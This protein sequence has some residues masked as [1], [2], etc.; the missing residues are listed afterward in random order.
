MLCALTLAAAGV[1]R[2]AYQPVAI[3]NSS[4]NADVIVEKTATPY[5]PILTSASI[6]QGTNNY[7]ATLFEVGLDTNNP[8][9]GV[10]AHGSTF[11]AYDN[12]NYSYKMAPTFVGPNGILMDSQVTNGTFTLVT[13]AAYATLSFIGL[14]GNGGN[15]IAVTVYHQDGSTENGNFSTSDWFG[16]TVGIA[17]IMGGRISQVYNLNTETDGNS[18]DGLGNPRM[19]HKEV[20][21]SNTTSP[22]TKIVLTWTGGNAG[23]H[24][25]VF[26]V[27]GA[28][29]AGG[30][31]TPIDVTGY[32]YDF[33]VEA[34]A[35]H[36]GRVLSQTMVGGTN[37]WATSQSMDGTDNTGASWY[38]QGYNLGNPA[39]GTYNSP[40]A[41]MSW[42]GLPHPG[43]YVTNSTGDHIFQ[44]PADYTTNNAIYISTT[45]TNDTI[46]LTTPAAF[47]GL[48]FMGAAGSGPV[49]VNIVINHQGGG[50]ET[51]VL[52]IPDWYNSTAPVAFIANGRVQ[53]PSAQLQDVKNNNPRLL[54]T[55]LVLQDAVNPVTSIY[56]ENTNS[57]GGRFSIFAIS[58]STGPLPP[59]IATQPTAVKAYQGS[60]VTFTSTA[61][62][63][64]TITY[65]W[66]MGTNDASGTNMV[67][68]DLA[69]SANISGVTSTILSLNNI[70][71]TQQA[72]YRIVASDS[73]GYVYSAAASLTVFSTQTDV[74][75]PGDGITS[76]NVSPFGDGPPANAIN[77]DMGTKFGANISGGVAALVI[78]PTTGLTILN[79]LRIYTGNDST[80]RDPASYKL[81]GSRD[82]GSTYTLISSNSITLPNGRNSGISGAPNPL[83][84]YV[85]EVRFANT[86][87]YTT[88][89]LSFPTYKNATSTQ[90]QFEELELLG[91]NDY[92]AVYFYPQPADGKAFNGGTVSLNGYA[93]NAT[94]QSWFK[95]TNGVYVPL[96]DGGNISG[97]QTSY[98][99]V[100]PATFA[101]VADYIAVASSAS[102][103]VTSS[104]AHLYIYT[105][106]TDVTVPTDPITGF[107]DTTG[108]RYGANTNASYVINNDFTVWENGGSGDSAGAGFPPFVGPVGVVLTP[109]VGS[110]VLTGIR[111]YPGADPSVNDPSSFVLEGSN[112]GGSTYT[113]IASGSLSLPLSRNDISLVVDPT[114]SAVQEILFSNTRGFT[115]YKLTFASNVD[116]STTSFLS[117]G[118]VE[119]LGVPGAGV[120]PPSQPTITTPSISGGNLSLSGTGGSPGSTFSVL[121]NSDLKVPVANWGTAMTGTFDGSGNFSVSLPVTTTNAGLFYLIKTP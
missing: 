22:V 8:A 69:N 94:S 43:A 77:D 116:P 83:T 61:T 10:P 56:L 81:E 33:I 112:N 119:F 95:G 92:S 110:T 34:T 6:D 48:S 18:G 109:A 103:Y 23:S 20:P 36:N 79:A 97:S 51:A 99:T 68:S 73:A 64:T 11:A 82:G 42:T 4:Y 91:V 40:N 100:N 98:L 93:I 104:I 75:M 38:E 65:K 29:T 28:T 67:Y 59:V 26:C 108:S 62:A 9:N 113:T 7:N 71:F 87:G 90:V 15:S 35:P 118:E 3:D 53:V 45:V 89:K 117:V 50:S 74:T 102:G 78:N 86:N 107:G 60:S 84:Q 101:D 24:S 19:Y 70:D 17:R 58:G 5:L 66:Q 39:S 55:D 47:S 80:G 114:L 106:N 96:A 2:A 111:I 46:T 52:S 120:N 21:L 16:G 30:A 13:P 25:G 72:N 88:Y 54:Q 41:D 44:M 76:L 85:T 14:G 57:S 37:L 63:N 105:T 12:P 49:N 115:S 1:A 31:I 27:S 32:D 121:T